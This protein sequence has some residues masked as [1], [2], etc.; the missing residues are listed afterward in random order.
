MILQSATNRQEFILCTSSSSS[1]NRLFQNKQQDANA[2]CDRN[3]LCCSVSEWEEPRLHHEIRIN[4]VTL[5]G[6]IHPNAHRTANLRCVAPRF[7]YAIQHS[8]VELYSMHLGLLNWI[9]YACVHFHALLLMLRM[10]SPI[11]QATASEVTRIE[12]CLVLG[13]AK[14]TW[15]VRSLACLFV[16]LYLTD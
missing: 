9:L 2:G 14:S 4:T 11:Y 5:T 7:L 6:R 3:C 8:K 15:R 13:W 10:N 1:E 12:N 16:C